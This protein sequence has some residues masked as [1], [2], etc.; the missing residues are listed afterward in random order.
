MG[1]TG[2]SGAPRA[3]MGEGPMPDQRSAAVRRGRLRKAAALVPL[4]AVSIAW[5]LSLIATEPS[6]V[7]AAKDPIEQQLPDLGS[8]PTQA[9]EEPAS[10][11]TKSPLVAGT[12]TGQAQQILATAAAAGI[13]PTALAAYQRAAT[14]INAAD[15][16]CQLP[17]QLLAAIGRVESDHGRADGNELDDNGVARPGIYGVALD[18]SNGT[19]LIVDTDAGRFDKDTS[20]DRVVGPM[21]FIPSTWAVVGVDADGDGVR[22]P[23][24]IDDAALG[25]AIYV[26]SGPDTLGTDEGRR[27]ALQRYN[28]SPAYVDLVLK[29]MAVY[30]EGDFPMSSEGPVL[31]GGGLPTA[32]PTS[33]PPAR[34][35]AG[36][37]STPS[38]PSRPPRPSQAPT[39]PNQ[40]AAPPT[41]PP[42]P[43]GQPT[44]GPTSAPPASP[45]GQP[46]SEPSSPPPTTP[47]S[48]PPGGGGSSG[49]IQVPGTQIS[50]PPLPSTSIAPVDG[51]LT[52][53]QAALQCTLE[54]LSS[55]LNPVKFQKCVDK[56]MGR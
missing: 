16:D 12:G 29:L 40:P 42:S 46:T 33:A 27:A 8:V 20:Y 35:G 39:R 14:I 45:S 56:Y 23:Q 28:P 48:P 4:A 53:T 15:A 26:C 55:L 7:S 3:D 37:P 19:T 5:T 9:I 1:F 43:S 11:A 32:P 44:S 2:R 51:L 36:A 25:A 34:P 24:D 18:G 49:G 50:V 21:R 10:V 52:A 13:P 54:G 31:A 6:G 17:W 30:L 41:K 47:S 22:D 38:T